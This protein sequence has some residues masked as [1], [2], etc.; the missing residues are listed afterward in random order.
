MPGLS[1]A[2]YKTE[3]AVPAKSIHRLSPANN[4]RRKFG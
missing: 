2:N 4:P 3:I 1:E